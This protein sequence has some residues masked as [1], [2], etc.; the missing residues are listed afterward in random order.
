MTKIEYIN[1][2]PIIH[3]YEHRGAPYLINGQ[4]KHKNHGETVESIV[5]WHRGLYT[6]VNPSTSWW[7][8]SDI[9]ELNAS[10]K[11]SEASLGHNVGKDTDTLLKRVNFYCKYTHS[12]LFIWADWDEETN[13]VVEYHMDIKEFKKFVLTF[14]RM[15]RDTSNGQMAIRF[16]K[17]SKKMQA[18][19]EERCA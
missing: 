18:W 14:T 8:G 7:E 10:V 9:E 13:A 6:E 5:K 11:S 19:F 2:M 16:R 4:A 17:S 1:T 3:D 12:S 15:S